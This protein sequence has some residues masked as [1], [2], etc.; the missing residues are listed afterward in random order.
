M[1][2]PLRLNQPMQPFLIQGQSRDARLL[3]DILHDEYFMSGI[4]VAR[5]RGIM[6]QL[7]YTSRIPDMLFF[8]FPRK[9]AG[10]HRLLAT[11]RGSPAGQELHLIPVL[12]REETRYLKGLIPFGLSGYILRPFTRFNARVQLDTIFAAMNR[13]PAE[14]LTLHHYQ[15]AQCLEEADPSEIGFGES[16]G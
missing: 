6:Q 2:K 15:G 8:E 11:L 3:Y 14:N 4:R 16:A 10:L 7:F 13:F 5:H 12:E 9:G 1:Q